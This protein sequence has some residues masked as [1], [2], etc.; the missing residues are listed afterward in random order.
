M[1]SSDALHLIGDK[2]LHQPAN[3]DLLAYCPSMD[4]LA[5]GSNDQQVLIYR[6]NGQRVYGA[7]VKAGSLKV[8]KV[9][10][11]PNG[12]WEPLERSP[13]MSEADVCLGQ[14]LAI[15]WSDGVVRLLGAD[16]SKIVHQISTADATPKRITCLGW[17]S[18]YPYPLPFD[19]K[20]DSQL[21]NEFGVHAPFSSAD[22]KALNLPRALALIDVE[23]SMPK[24]SP[25]PAGGTA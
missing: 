2:L 22:G 14:L 8:E 19:L 5:L 10:W 20:P 17:G 6:L 4:L 21:L 1:A 23:S 3:H 11:K 25:L 7:T 15:A 18:T 13:L 9:Q 24:L 12:I 16:S